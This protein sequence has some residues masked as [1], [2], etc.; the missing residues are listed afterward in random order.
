MFKISN[1]I[2]TE[3]KALAVGDEAYNITKREQVEN[4]CE[5]VL[6]IHDIFDQVY[7]V[8]RP[9]NTNEFLQ[10]PLSYVELYPGDR[11]YS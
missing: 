1:E 11:S 7:V 2:V 10:E 5:I 6:F 3:G 4:P 9:P 8:L